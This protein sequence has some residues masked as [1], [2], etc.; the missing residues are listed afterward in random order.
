MVQTHSIPQLYIFF[1]VIPTFFWISNLFIQ[2]MPWS[3]S[4]IYVGMVL[5]QSNL[6][7]RNWKVLGNAGSC[8]MIW[9]ALDQ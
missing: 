3:V 6:E 9:L 8:A 2:P 4:Q 5:T 7:G 1:A